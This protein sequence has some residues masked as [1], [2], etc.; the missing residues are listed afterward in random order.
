VAIAIGVAGALALSRFLGTLVFDVS[1]A[2]PATLAATALLLGL[3]GLVA[4]WL[5]ARR[6]ALTDPV[7]AIRQE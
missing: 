6:A 4:C 7:E 3:V 2:D 1:T 5:P